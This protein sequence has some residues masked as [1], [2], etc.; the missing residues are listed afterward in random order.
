MC[1]INPELYDVVFLKDFRKRFRL[2]YYKHKEKL[3]ELK[4]NDMFSR[5]HDH[6]TN[7]ARTPSSP[8]ELLL[9]GSFRCL[10]HGWTFY[11]AA[12]STDASTDAQINFFLKHAKYDIT[13]FY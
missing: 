9:L 1:A 10:G 6:A 12:E 4:T 8:M 11:D 2:P 13:N 5:W 7:A 3:N